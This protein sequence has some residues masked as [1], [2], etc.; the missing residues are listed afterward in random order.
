MVQLVFFMLLLI[1][2]LIAL[3]VSYF[4]FTFLLPARP[5]ALF[6]TL[7]KCSLQFILRNNVPRS[8]INLKVIIFSYHLLAFNLQVKFH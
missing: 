1:S 4:C 3:S 2:M 8:V 5:A 7:S 6:S